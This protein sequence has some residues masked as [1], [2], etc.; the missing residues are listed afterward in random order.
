MLV[1]ESLFTVETEAWLQSIHKPGFLA[2]YSC[3]LQLVCGECVRLCHTA[4]EKF[5][6]KF[7]E[8]CASH[9]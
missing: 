9:F 1:T 5:S 4:E 8:N 6:T 2:I 7:E 3:P